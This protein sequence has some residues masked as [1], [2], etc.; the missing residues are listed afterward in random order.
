MLRIDRAATV[1]RWSPN[2][3]KFAVG[4]GAKIIC[5]CY[6]DDKNDWWI[7]KKIKKHIRSTI[8]S[9]D[10]HPNNIILAAGSTDYKAKL[11][12]AYIPSV[13]TNNCFPNSWTNNLT[14]TG[15]LI[16]EY[17]SGGGKSFYFKD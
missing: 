1:V 6:F 11:F 3:D 9:L 7:C 4:T 5:V 17:G 12:T 10:W 14:N 2:E 16:D 15:N 8:T 13:D